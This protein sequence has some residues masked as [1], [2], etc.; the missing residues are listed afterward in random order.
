MYNL[1]RSAYKFASHLVI[2]VKRSYFE[3]TLTYR[4]SYD[5]RIKSVIFEVGDD[6]MLLF[7]KEILVA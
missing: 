6:E 3:H 2:V 1:D 7:R 4:I 5:L